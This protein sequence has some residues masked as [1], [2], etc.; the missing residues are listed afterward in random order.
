MT[1]AFPDDR[2]STG[3]IEPG[4]EAVRDGLDAM[5]VADPT[6]SAQV[7]VTWHGRV[8][9]DLAGGPGLAADDITGVFSAGK[10]VAATVVALLLERGLFD[11]D[12]PMATYWPKFAAAGKAA[13]TVRQVLSH[14]AGL[15]G[16][17]GG[18]T[19]EEL[20]DSAAAAARIAASAPYWEPG[21]AHGYHALT[22]GMLMEELVRRVTG[23]SLQSIYEEQIRA[24]RG[25]D[26]Y[27]G[28]PESE[29][30]RFREVRPPT[31]THEQLAELAGSGWGAE[32]LTALAFNAVNEEFP[33]AGGRMGPN[34]RDMRAVGF[35]SINGIG[36]ARGLA[37]VYAAILG[38]PDAEPLLSP[39]TIAAVSTQQ[40]FGIDRVLLGMSTAFG[41]VYMKPHSRM[42]F[43]SYRAF[44]HD[45]AGGALAFA[46]PL[47][48]MAFGYIPMP[49]QLPGGAD[50]KA[51]KLSEIARGCINRIRRAS[52]AAGASG[53]PPTSPVATDP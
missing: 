30:P 39:E 28:L 11:L 29:E 45:G 40:A 32:S 26:F 16:V 38:G 34:N 47:S 42:E 3:R 9:V 25:I 13:I 23:R 15:V 22:I 10:G 31:P 50:P 24:P 14:R 36:S 43:G 19:I 8:V 27:L 51:L 20:A 33:P 5:L 48:G 17:D 53:V 37:G 7:A 12:E 44:G 35:T 18:F 41:I 1:T 52:A 2:P 21:T 4:F 46:D 49:M 6:F